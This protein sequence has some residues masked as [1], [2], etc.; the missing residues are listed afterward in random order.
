MRVLQLRIILLGFALILFSLPNFSYASE[1]FN[2]LTGLIFQKDLQGVKDMLAC[3]MDVNIRQEQSGAT[4]LIVACSMEGT[5]EIVKFLLSKGADI[6]VKGAVDGRTP[7]IWAAGNS[8]E[9]TKLL[10]AKGADVKA[11]GELTT[12]FTDGTKIKFI[13]SATAT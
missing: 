1:D 12:R 7:L 9:N 10:I 4:P 13:L 11:K 3:G 2:K 6:K 5:E 8:M